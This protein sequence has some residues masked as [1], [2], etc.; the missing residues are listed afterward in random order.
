MKKFTVVIHS[1][2]PE[3]AL[4]ISRALEDLVDKHD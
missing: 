1:E 2:D 3:A 4:A